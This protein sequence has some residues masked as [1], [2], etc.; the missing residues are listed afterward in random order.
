MRRRDILVALAGTCLRP[1]LAQSQNS[2]KMYRIGHLDA[3]GK[4]DADR[5][6]A[7]FYAELAKLGFVQD[8]DFTLDR[9]SADGQLDR[10]PT[11]AAAI[12]AGRPDLVFAPPAP[13]AAAVRAL[14]STIP[15]V[16][17]FVNDP[18]ALGFAKT[19]AIAGLKAPAIHW[20]AEFVEIGGLMS[21]G[22]NFPDLAR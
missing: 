13:A 16:F 22:A 1:A 3:G 12:V 18:I 14:T 5:L 15:I 19:L 21:Y 8:R 4:A 20:T 2:G 9:R 10:L 11:L 7:P 17:C 6:I